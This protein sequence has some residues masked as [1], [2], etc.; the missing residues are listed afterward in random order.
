MEQQH[1]ARTV[2]KDSA[3]ATN[4]TNMLLTGHYAHQ[5]NHGRPDGHGQPPKGYKGQC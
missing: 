5:K 1:V 4:M 3:S 2:C